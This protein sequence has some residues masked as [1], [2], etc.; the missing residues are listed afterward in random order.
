MQTKQAQ[1]GV[2]LMEVMV[3]VAIAAIMAVIA[4]PSFGDFVKNM[5][6]STTMTQLA[7]DL[8]RARVEAI[9]H[10]SWV[11]V[12]VRNTAGTGCGTGAS[13]NNGWAVCNISNSAATTCDAS[14]SSD[15]NPFV[16]HNAVES[17]LT[18]T[19]PAAPIRFN[20]DGT[21]G[22]GAVATLTLCCKAKSTTTSVATIAGTGQINR[23]N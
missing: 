12:C 22:T 10:N 17:G 21:Q 9:K 19:G 7:S 6:L 20:P 16:L 18:L 8:N 23:Q 13:W 5:R 2:T 3:V 1:T 11:L 4:G 15:P 14:T